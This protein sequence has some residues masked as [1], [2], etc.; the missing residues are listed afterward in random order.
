MEIRLTYHATRRMA[1][2]GLSRED[3]A[4]IIEQ[5]DE[6]EHRGFADNYIATLRGTRYRVIVKVD[7]DPLLVITAHE[8]YR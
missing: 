5:A 3:V 2:A 1:E 7:S 4:A 6:I 8:Y